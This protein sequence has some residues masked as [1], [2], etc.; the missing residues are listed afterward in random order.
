MTVQPCLYV[1]EDLLHS[2]LP[3]T[4]GDSQWHYSDVQWFYGECHRTGS[5]EWSDLQC[6]C[7]G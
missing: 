6:Q 4:T 3:G 1:P 7:G 5:D 2:P